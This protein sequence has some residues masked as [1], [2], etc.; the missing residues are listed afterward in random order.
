MKNKQIQQNL[1]HG[2]IFLA[3]IILVLFALSLSTEIYLK[4]GFAFTT[5]D[6]EA[7]ETKVVNERKHEDE[8]F[9]EIQNLTDGFKTKD[10]SITVVA[11]TNTGN[12]SWINGNEVK[13]NNEGVL[14][15][16][17]DLIIGKNE[18]IV[19]VENEEGK[20]SI[21]K[22]TVIREK[23]EELK[24]EEPESPQETIPTE[25]IQPPATNPVPQPVPTPEP[26]PQ[27]SPIMGLKLQCS[28]TNTQPFIGQTVALICVVKDQNNNYVSG[29]S[30]N[31][32]V[33]WSSGNQSYSLSNSNGSGAMNISFV[34]PKG[35][36]G[37]IM[38]SVRVSKDGLTVTSNFSLTVQ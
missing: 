5:N 32:T 6:T 24:K 13:V 4:G 18:I 26:D 37:Q 38:G 11:F 14:E 30:G 7:K 29:A 10:K 8:I 28:I 33:N 34:V 25:P 22:L 20:E 36:S 12:K 9:L 31:V 23:K 19:E 15:D 1:K 35:N 21:Q 3:S 2:Y 17:V 27:P 16:K